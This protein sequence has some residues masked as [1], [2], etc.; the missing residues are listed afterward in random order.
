MH[1]CH[2]NTRFLRAGSEENTT[3]TCNGLVARGHRVSL[4]HGREFHPDMCSQLDP[5]VARHRL[6]ELV[7]EIRP[8]QDLI[9]L[10]TVSRLLREIRPDVVHTHASKAGIIGRFAA[11]IAGVKHIVHSVH[12]LPFVN[13]PPPHRWL[14]LHLER[15][16]ARGTTAFIDISETMRDL[17]VAERIGDANCHH[18]VLSG[19][20]AQK[21]RSTRRPADWRSVIDPRLVGVADPKFLLLAGA[22]EPRKRQRD[23]LPVFRRIADADPHAV[24]LLAGEGK[25]KPVIEAAIEQLGLA[26]RALC[27][28]FRADL[29]QLIALADVCL[30]TSM[31]E[32]L[33]RTVVQYALCGRAVVSTATPGIDRIVVQGETGFLVTLDDLGSMEAPILNLLRDLRLRQA[34]EDAARRLDLSGWD[35]HH[36]VE[37]IGSIYEGIARSGSRAAIAGRI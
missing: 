32:G 37:Q 7:N 34:M 6:P 2:I 19:M 21:F 4:I 27:L 9:A 29:A 36:M 24:L 17:C 35:A 20:D 15:L 26:G 3:I 11:R 31:R 12:I 23:F 16:A 8:A 18:V 22:F 13:V 25:D 30:Q 14:Y 28:G 5:A 1:I 10:F 33:P